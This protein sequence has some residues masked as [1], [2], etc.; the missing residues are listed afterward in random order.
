LGDGAPISQEI[1][2][3][4]DSSE[5]GKAVSKLDQLIAKLGK[6]GQAA[7]EHGHKVETSA[8]K[9]RHEFGQVGHASEYAKTELKELLEFTGILEG[10]ELMK[11]LAES[12]IDIGKEAIVAAAAAERMNRVIDSASGGKAEGKE[13]REWL[14]ELSKKTEFSEAQV[15]GSFVDLK[16]VGASDQQAKL[17][18][19]A[20]A[21]IA[22]V[23]KNKDEAFNTTVEAFARLERTGKVSNRTLAPLGLGEKDFAQLPQFKGMNAK[24]IKAATDKGQ[25]SKND[26]YALIMARTGEKAIGEKAAANADLLGT[27]LSKLTELPEKFYKKLA[28]TGA[29]K[30]LSD[31]IGGVLEKLDPESPTGKRIFGSLEHAFTSFA[32]TVAGID[33]GEIADVITDDILPAISKMIGLIKPAVEFIGDAARAGERLYHIVGGGKDGNQAMLDA[34]I[35]GDRAKLGARGELPSQKDHGAVGN[36]IYRYTPIGYIADSL[37][38]RNNKDAVAGGQSITDGVTEGIK[39]G[40]PAVESAAASMGSASH[41]AFMSPAGIDAHS[42]SKKFRYGGQMAAE[43]V[44]LG[45]ESKSDRIADAMTSIS[46]PSFSSGGSLSTTARGAV[47]LSIAEGAVQINLTAGHG[48]KDIAGMVRDELGRSL[49]PMLIDALESAQDGR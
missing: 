23:S 6:S 39:A 4:T 41:E 27:K 47:H 35:G 22:A 45:F 46:G 12:V 8:Q 16:R 18:M 2:L 42:P 26:L 29:I 21:D 5:L 48:D 19:K 33:F 28:D 9:I 40:T 30:T 20:A 14:A 3:P 32:D 44:A 15:E 7:T 17:A 25:V 31:A 10:I 43:G 49:T 38:A 11:K 37:H 34:G 1:K 13:N 36:A 24:Q